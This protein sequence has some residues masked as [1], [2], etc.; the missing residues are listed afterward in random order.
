MVKS[1]S[2]T[3]ER[4]KERTKTKEG[5]KRGKCGRFPDKQL[6][7]TGAFRSNSSDTHALW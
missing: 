7:Q 1:E 6:R 4:N 5:C 2:Y 3:V